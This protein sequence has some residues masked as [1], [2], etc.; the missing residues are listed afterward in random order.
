MEN[1]IFSDIGTVLDLNGPTLSF[2]TQ[3]TG[4]TGIGT[5]VGGTGGASV[6]LVGIATATFVGSADN[7]GT[8]F[9]LTMAM[10]SI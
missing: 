9:I 2:I 1:Q 7:I 8:I 10:R 5:S 3:P 4:V 6:E